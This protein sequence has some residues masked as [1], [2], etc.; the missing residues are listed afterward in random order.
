MN[1]EIQD[2][3]ILKDNEEILED[4][5]PFDTSSIVVYSR[6]WTIETMYSQIM[7]KNINLN[8]KYQR[9]NAWT[10]QKRSQLIESIIIG[11][12]VPEIVL[13][14]DPLQKKSF[15]V[16][17]GKQRLL[18][19]AGFINPE[20][21]R[22]WDNGGKLIKLFV[23][24]KLNG[25]TFE[26]LKSDAKY[27][28]ELREF[29]NSALRC[30]II[31]NF[32]A[33]DILYDIFYRLNSGSVSLSTQELRQVLNRGEFAD[34]LIET[35]NTPQSLHYI[36]NLSE[37]D[38]RLRDIEVLLRCISMI[39]FS[40][41]YNGNLKQFLDNS[42][43]EI[44]KEWKTTYEIKLKELYANINNSIEILKNIFEDY[45]LI[46]RKFTNDKAEARFNRVILE[47]QLFFFVRL[48]SSA[49]NTDSVSKFKNGF[50]K[51]CQDDKEFRSSVES[52]T[53]N[54]DNYRIRFGKFQEL[55]NHAFGVN[56]QIN[57][58]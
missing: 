7:G 54:I 46:G 37:P 19:I 49:I 14:E 48:E 29:F 38:K 44:T 27:S 9:R 28:D 23:K 47:V 39:E 1:N 16:I 41:N 52:S 58:F 4:I 53:K 10:D 42:M 21:F 50:I 3:D 30:T 45:N 36:M 20:E 56:L 24:E 5:A 57:P 18:T 13:A 31:T 6:D 40:K 11:Y 25:L 51:L 33:N 34:Y 15:A 43:G 35:T 2:D 55:M 22:Y 8:P 12:P 32:Q 17:D 26:S